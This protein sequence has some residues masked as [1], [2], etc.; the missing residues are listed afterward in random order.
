MGLSAGTCRQ[1]RSKPLKF[2]PGQ[3]FIY[4]Q[5]PTNGVGRRSPHRNG[6]CP[7]RR[8]KQWLPPS[9]TTLTPLLADWRRSC[10]LVSCWPQAWSWW[11][12]LL[13]PKPHRRPPSAGKPTTVYMEDHGR[14]PKRPSRRPAPQRPART[15][16]LERPLEPARQPSPAGPR[17][18]GEQPWLVRLPLFVCVSQCHELPPRNSTRSPFARSQ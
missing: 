2:S 9:Q 11:A 1:G 16:R 3:P 13:A 7:S 15:P 12:A 18:P 5:H 10:C 6:A 14:S 8:R 17:W 4:V